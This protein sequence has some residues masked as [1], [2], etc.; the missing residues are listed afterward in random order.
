MNK[1]DKFE[2]KESLTG[3][4]EFYQNIQ[5]PYAI[6]TRPGFSPAR[7]ENYDHLLNALPNSLAGCSVLDLGCNA[8][9]FSIEAKKRG[10]ARVVG[11]DYSELYIRQAKFCA[12]A[13]SLDIEYL[14]SDVINFMESII[15]KEKFDYIIF[16]GTLYHLTDPIRVPRLIGKLC[17]R[18]CLV[19]TVGVHPQLRN[20]QFNIIQLPRP[21]VTHSGT[22]WMN[23]QAMNHIFMDLGGFKQS[24]E[25]FN[26]SRISALYSK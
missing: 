18:E 9:A 17:V 6:E 2:L 1:L 16:I 21:Q 12:K 3:L 7:G 14:Q 20:L 5:L 10:A 22:V 15:N 26:G 13:L 8:G 24:K 4:G 19:E 25:I 23:L 11:V